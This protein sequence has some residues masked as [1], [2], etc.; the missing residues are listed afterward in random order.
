MLK[1]KY[2]KKGIECFFNKSFETALLNFSLALKETD[3]SKEA[4]I[5]AILSDLA[6]EK[7]AEAGALFEYYLLSKE[8]GVKDSEDII[9]EILNSVE[10]SLDDIE[11]L[12]IEN[13]IETKINEENGIAYDDFMAVVKAKNNFKEAFENMMFSTK[14][15]IHTKEDFLDFLEQLIENGFREISLNYLETALNMFPNDQKLIALI[16]K[17]Q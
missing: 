4:R 17:V 7:E 14:V 10:L 3:D 8:S 5:G 2:I 6:M 16:K 1:N 15:I 11:K 9:E 13:Q 12:F